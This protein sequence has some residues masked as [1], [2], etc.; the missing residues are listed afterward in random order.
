MVS[1]IRTLASGAKGCGFEFQDVGSSSD[2]TI[3]KHSILEFFY[4]LN[5]LQLTLLHHKNFHKNALFINRGNRYILHRSIK[6][7]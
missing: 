2:R 1:H 7:K 5:F 6:F 3:A 4:F